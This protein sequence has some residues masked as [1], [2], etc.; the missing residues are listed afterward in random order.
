M[1]SLL[2]NAWKFYGIIKVVIEMLLAAWNN[3]ELRKLLDSILAE[4]KKL[5]PQDRENMIRDAAGDA[6]VKKFAD[7]LK[8]L[9]HWSTTPY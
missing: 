6:P 1:L 3:P 2:A 8:S 5:S 9:F 7:Y 4:L